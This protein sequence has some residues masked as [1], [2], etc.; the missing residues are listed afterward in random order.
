MRIYAAQKERHGPR[1]LPIE[2]RRAGDEIVGIVAKQPW[3]TEKMIVGVPLCD[4]SGDAP[5]RPSLVGSD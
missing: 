5:T 2:L 4:L 3:T 1:L